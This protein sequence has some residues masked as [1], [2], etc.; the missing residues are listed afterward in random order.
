MQAAHLVVTGLT[1]QTFLLAFC[2]FSSRKSLP[3][4]MIC[5][6]AS[7]YLVAAEEL[8]RMF[9]SEALKEALES[10]NVTW[11]LFPNMPLGTVDSGKEL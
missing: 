2:R 7:T 4:M 10:Q 1:V 8:Q 6:N 11:Q 5:D 3:K 9:N